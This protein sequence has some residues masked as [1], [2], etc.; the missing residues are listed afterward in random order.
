MTRNNVKVFTEHLRLSTLTVQVARPRNFPSQCYFEA[1]ATPPQAD[2][3]CAA[4][5][6]PDRLHTN[7]TSRDGGKS[8]SQKTGLHFASVI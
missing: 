5:D 1:R 7:S 4:C 6:L 8:P 3:L 2:R